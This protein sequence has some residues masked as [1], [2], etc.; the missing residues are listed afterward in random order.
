[1]TYSDDDDLLYAC[2]P[3]FEI[4]RGTKRM[5]R[6]VDEGNFRVAARRFVEWY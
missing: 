5:L 4:T 2:S 6:V 3:F 1:M